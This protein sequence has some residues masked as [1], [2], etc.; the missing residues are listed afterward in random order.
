MSKK[1][2]E[3]IKELK[4]LAATIKE[5]THKVNLKMS[6]YNIRRVD[7]KEFFARSQ[8]SYENFKKKAGKLLY[9]VF[10][11]SSIY[12]IIGMLLAAKGILMLGLGV[13]FLGAFM[14]LGFYTYMRS[15][16]KYL[17][18]KRKKVSEKMEMYLKS[19]LETVKKKL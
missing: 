19:S 4:E 10:S 18:K 2:D 6:K 11:V 12:F 13:C 17:D 7:I 1:L 15:Y 3:K 5:D 8:E 16:F 14:I 9:V